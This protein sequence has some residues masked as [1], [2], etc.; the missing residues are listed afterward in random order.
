MTIDC[1]A[2]QEALLQQQVVLVAGVAEVK[3]KGRGEECISQN[4][5]ILRAPTGAFGMFYFANSQRKEKKRYVCI[6]SEPPSLSSKPPTSCCL[7]AD[8]RLTVS[9]VDR[10]EPGKKGS[11]AIGLRLRPTSD[12]S[13]QLKMLQIKFLEESGMYR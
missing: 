1:I 13:T 12:L 2:F 5:R 8:A 9:T 10:I 3:S 7:I 11:K 4:L 6:P